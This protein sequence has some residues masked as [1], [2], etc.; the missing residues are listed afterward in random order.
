LNFATPDGTA[1]VACGDYQATSGTFNIAST[2]AKTTTLS[3]HDALPI[4]EPNETFTVNLSGATGATITDATGLGTITNDD[5]PAPTLAI[6]EVTLAKVNTRTTSVVFIVTRNANISVA[7][8]LNFAT[9][10]G[11]AT[12]AGGECQD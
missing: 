4:L 11:T 7:T 10:D 12:I 1:D 8:S 2:H 3:L 9:T 5:A 6:N